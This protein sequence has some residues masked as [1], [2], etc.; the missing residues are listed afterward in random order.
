MA[1]HRAEE[2]IRG[3]GLHLRLEV[4]IPG[5]RPAVPIQ[6]QQACGQ[7]LILVATHLLLLG[8]ARLARRNLV[9]A[10]P[11][12]NRIDSSSRNDASTFTA[13]SGAEMALAVNSAC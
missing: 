10:E 8:P 13:F 2:I 3:E 6:Q 12:F 5:E 9:L 1:A 7:C 11:F 4:R